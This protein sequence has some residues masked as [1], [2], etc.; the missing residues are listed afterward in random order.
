MAKGDFKP[1]TRKVANDRKRNL[2]YILLE[3]EKEEI[4]R[5]RA[6]EGKTKE[7]IG[8]RKQIIAAYEVNYDIDDAIAA[9]NDINNKIGK[10]A[11]TEEMIKAW[12]R[13]YEDKN[14]SRE[15]D[16]LEKEN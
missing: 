6:I 7:I 5:K 15:D 9:M 3:M 8:P 4:K 16:D 13:E 12:I 14:N 2:Q 11:Y 1:G 10:Q